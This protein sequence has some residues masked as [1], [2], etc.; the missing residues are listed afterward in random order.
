VRVP[1]VYTLYIPLSPCT[2]NKQINV[3]LSPPPFFF[4]LL[5]VGNNPSKN[6]TGGVGFIVGAG[7]GVYGILFFLFF[8]TPTAGRSGR[9]SSG[10]EHSAGLPCLWDGLDGA[11]DVAVCMYVYVGGWGLW[12]D[13][14]MAVMVGAAPP[15]LRF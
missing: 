2:T 4:F 10:M 9:R 12:K 7:R 1:G 6:R 3:G 5:R 8:F 14:R 11:G 15:G 13:G